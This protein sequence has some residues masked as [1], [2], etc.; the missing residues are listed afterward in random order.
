MGGAAVPAA[1][2][3][4]TTADWAFVVSLFSF[5]VSLAGFVWAEDEEVCTQVAIT[6]SEDLLALR[7]KLHSGR[8]MTVESMRSFIRNIRTAEMTEA[9]FARVVV[10]VEGATEREA[11]PIYA[12]ALGLPRS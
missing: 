8:D 12:R 1:A 3:A 2:T 4:W 5:A 9:Y 11:L 10:V 7:K 6:S